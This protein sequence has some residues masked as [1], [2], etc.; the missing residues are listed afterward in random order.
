MNNTSPW[1][2]LNLGSVNVGGSS[3]EIVFGKNYGGRGLRQFRH[4]CSANVNFFF[5]GDC[6]NVNNSTAPWTLQM[7]RSYQAPASN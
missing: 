4:R 7:A 2:R 6:G 5:F 3:G 1:A